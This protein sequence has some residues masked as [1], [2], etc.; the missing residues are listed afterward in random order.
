MPHDTRSSAS[1]GRTYSFMPTPATTRASAMK[2]SIVR[3]NMELNLDIH[4]LSHDEV[5]DYLQP[6]RCAQHDVAYVIGEKKLDVI[7]IGVK[8]Q[9]R[10]R[11]RNAAQRRRRHLAVR[12]HR[13]DAAA[14]L[15]T[16][17]NHVGQLVQDFRQVA[18]RALLEQDRR[19]EE[20]PVQR[21]YAL[22]KF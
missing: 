1:F 17:A 22:R 6:D 13:A 11:D 16:L 12:A 7:R 3:I 21:R 14:Q 20:A 18:A 5:A 15:E 8:H 9:H 10:Y 4:D 19:H 2:T